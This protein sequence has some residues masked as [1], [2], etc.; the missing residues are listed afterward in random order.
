[1]S[2]VT[3]GHEK[4]GSQKV[5]KV[6]GAMRV[7]TSCSGR[8]HIFNQAR[9]LARHGLLHRLITDYPR[10]YPARYGIPRERVMPLLGTGLLSQGL[11]R[12]SSHLSDTLQ[13]SMSN[14]LHNLFSRRLASVLP[15][16]ADFFIGLSS[17]CLEALERSR[18]QG[19]PCAVDHGSLHQAEE[20]K[21][22]LEEGARWGVLP[23]DISTDWVIEKETAEF[24]K[25]DHVFALSTVARDSLVLHGVP[26]ERIFV[27]PC[28][29]DISAFCP[30][31]HEDEVFRVIQVAGVRL[32]KGTLDLLDAFSRARIP[33]AE[34]WHVGG[35]LETS[36]LTDLIERL[37]IPGV[38]F[39]KPVPQNRLREFYVNSS[40][41]VLASVADGFGM[42][43]PQAMACGLPV[44]VTE[45]VGA[46]DLVIDGYNGF[47]VPIRAPEVIAERLRVLHD[48]PD[49]A[50]EMGK[51]ARET[52][53][54]GYTWKDYGDRLAVFV[55]SLGIDG[56]CG[57]G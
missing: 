27:N 41:F 5:T 30:D 15:A 11:R 18:E 20:R 56:R 39:I 33:G 19:I 28:G 47:I 45:N 34:L 51:R 3:A 21:L 13:H 12:I 17:F 16:D 48:H 31:R 25:A 37:R 44:I 43:V 8:F 36:R 9:E 22:I 32:G 6:A 38:R 57:S 24:G 52:V 10:W 53:L 35:G 46:S 23:A 4:V 26:V 2:R 40:V 7:V 14:A 55:R 29:V 54:N 1:M 49:I 50:R 42:V